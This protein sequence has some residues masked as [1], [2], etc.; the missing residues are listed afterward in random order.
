MIGLPRSRRVRLLAAVVAVGCST[1]DTTR[2]APRD[3][4]IARTPAA[5]SVDS[6]RA[7]LETAWYERTRMLDL[8]GDGQPD[9]ARLVAAG[10]RPDSLRISLVFVVA[11]TEKY[12]ETWGSSYELQHLDSARL[13]STRLAGTLRARLDSVLAS[14][15]VERLGAPGV[16]VMA[17]DS[18]TL[19]R[20]TPRPTHRISFAYGFE[21]TVRLVWDAANDRF[22]RLWSCC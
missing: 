9:S 6:A 2:E 16:R 1:S 4:A 7:I 11:G 15:V 19:A 22:V 21:S 20:L 3:S 8:T 13:R 10:Q 12:R 18:A 14:V 5:D 17:E